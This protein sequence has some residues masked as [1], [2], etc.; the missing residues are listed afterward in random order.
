LAL[1][2]RR[3]YPGAT[4]QRIGLP[5]YPFAKE[6]YWIQEA[7]D[8]PV[9]GNEKAVGILHPLVHSNTSDF[10][11][12]RFSAVF[13]GEEFFLRDHQVLQQ[14]VLPGVAYL[15]MVRV[16]IEKSMPATRTSP[17]LVLYNAAWVQ[18]FVAGGQQQIDITLLLDDNVPATYDQIHYEISSRH[19]DAT[20]VHFE[21]QASFTD[22][23]VPEKLDVAQL[24]SQMNA[25]TLPPRRIYAAFARMGL[26]YGPAHQGITA[27]HKGDG[28]VM[29][30]LTLPVTA[31]QNNYVLHPAL[32]DSALQAAIGLFDDLDRLPAQPLLPFALA[33]L[34][35]IAACTERMVAWVRYAPDSEAGQRV[36]KLDID[37]CDEAGNMCVQIRG[38]AFRIMDNGHQYTQVNLG[39]N[40]D[41]NETYYQ[42]LIQR[43]LDKELSDEEA[44]DLV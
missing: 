11:Q 9:A 38:F 16:A 4:P 15:E 26:H 35:I 2:W 23:L 31:A 5:V 7:A 28:Q 12:Q 37:V 10:S 6:R 13:S 19:E 30:D 41:F 42:Q 44:I 25:G 17:V 27:I 29:A 43:V 22:V 33:S 14:R 39:D 18:P 36:T 40:L 34:K 21:G 3:F 24:R 32:M 8:A 1:D 20:I